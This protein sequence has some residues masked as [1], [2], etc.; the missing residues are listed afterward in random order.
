MRSKYR[1]Y[2]VIA[3]GTVY[4]CREHMAMLQ[5]HTNLSESGVAHYKGNV[6]DDPSFQMSRFT[7]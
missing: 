5:H 2:V 7:S 3:E 4:V 6:W 1:W